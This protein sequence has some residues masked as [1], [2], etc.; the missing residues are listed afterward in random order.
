MHTST[1]TVHLP[2]EV[3]ERLAALARTTEQPEV[4]LAAEAIRSYVELQ[5][6]QI[7]E[8]EQ[9]LRA[10]DA[11]EFASDDEVAAVFAKWTHDRPVAT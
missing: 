4:G 7:G 11:G 5:E 1:L 8:I 9:G 3:R 10:A 6:W 2:T